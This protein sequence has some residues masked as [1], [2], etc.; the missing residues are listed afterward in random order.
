LGKRRTKP[1]RRKRYLLTQHEKP[2][3]PDRRHATRQ[4]NAGSSERPRQHVESSN[5]SLPSAINIA[6]AVHMKQRLIPAVK[7]LH[8]AIAAKADEWTDI[9]KIGRTHLQDATPL[10][11]GQEWSG[12]EERPRPV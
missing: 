10:T 6:A 4:Q 8:D 12:Y 2:L 11:L 3:L 9:V 7:E 1:A 5:D